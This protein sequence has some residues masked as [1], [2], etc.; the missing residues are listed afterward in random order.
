M[1]RFDELECFV[2][3]VAAGSITA[4]AQHLGVAKSV[5][6]RRLSELEDRLGTRLLTRTT[7]RMSL[8]DAGRGYHDRALRILADI[9]E[10]D[11]EATGSARELEGRLRLAAP[12]SFGL[13]HLSAALDEF[14][15]ANPGVHFD[16]DLNDRPV[17]LVG[18]GFDLALRIAELQDSSLVARRLSPIRHVVCAS[19]DYWAEHGLP[20]TPDDL[21]S[22]RALRYT[23]SPHQAWR[24][25]GPDGSNGE[26][27]LED[28]LQANNGEFLR[29]AGKAGI[30]VLMQPTFIVYQAIEAGELQ[31]VL[32]EYR[33]RELSA[34]AVYPANRHVPARVRSFVDF[35]ADR[36][37]SRPYWDECLRRRSEFRT[38][39]PEEGQIGL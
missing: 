10:A 7:R 37:G 9:A 14:A 1:N 18:E 38:D 36:F 8:T 23:N 33:W 29:Q 15:L 31:P 6:S 21:L 28:R 35:L 3:V 20:A 11:A 16:V 27:R 19:P 25:V 17:D 22:H 32:T 34:Y 26:I 2:R 4:A 13:L 24:Y 30:G 39:T 5:V 12:L